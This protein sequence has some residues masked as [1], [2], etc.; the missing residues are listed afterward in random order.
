LARLR[1]DLDFFTEGGELAIAEAP[2]G[3]SRTSYL[4]RVAPVEDELWDIR[5]RD[6]RPGIR[7][8]GA[9]AERDVFIALVWDHRST[10]GGAE[11]REWRDFILRGKTA[12]RTLFE[13]YK[14]HS[15][16]SISD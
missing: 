15:G 1:A 2:F 11:S 9:F 12:W 5:S 16:E 10:L 3:K 14:P 4:A 13:T 8:L 6:P 7:V